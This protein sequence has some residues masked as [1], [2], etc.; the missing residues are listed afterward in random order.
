MIVVDLPTMRKPEA[1]GEHVSCRVIL[2][3]WITQYMHYSI[4]KLPDNPIPSTSTPSISNQEEESLQQE[5]SH[6]SLD[7]CKL[8]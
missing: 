7:S 5:S 2:I 3:K 6:H 8:T 1:D 4:R